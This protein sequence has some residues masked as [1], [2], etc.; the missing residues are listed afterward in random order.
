MRRREVIEL[1]RQHKIVTQRTSRLSIV[2]Q[3][4]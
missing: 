3:N 2:E 1:V 4:L